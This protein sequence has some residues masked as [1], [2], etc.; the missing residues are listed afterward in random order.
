MRCVGMGLQ[1]SPKPENLH[2]DGAIADIFVHA[3]GLQETFSGEGALRSVEKGEEQGVVASREND[4]RAGRIRQPPKHRIELPSAEMEAATL[5]VTPR[6]PPPQDRVDSGEE[7]SKPERLRHVVI[8]AELQPN[9]SIDLVPPAACGDDHRKIGM[10]PKITQ[11]TQTV[12]LAEP[13]AKDDQIRLASGELPGHV[14]PAG[15]GSGMNVAGF[16]VFDDHVP[17]G[18]IIVHDQN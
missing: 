14:R 1:L 9:D 4:G 10:R 16:E 15:G 5:P 8:G 11:Q 7:L 12:F 6:S 13:K 3:R 18:G 17:H 2:I